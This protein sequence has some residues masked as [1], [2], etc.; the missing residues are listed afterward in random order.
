M[1]M[2]LLENGH[3]ILA[4]KLNEFAKEDGDGLLLETGVNLY[5]RIQTS[6]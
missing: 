4:G 5:Q 2:I 3:N 6:L 1:V